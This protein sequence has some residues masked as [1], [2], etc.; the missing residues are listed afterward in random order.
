[1]ANVQAVVVK[2]TPSR[3]RF[4]VAGEPGMPQRWR[5]NNSIPLAEVVQKMEVER[6]AVI[7]YF[8]FTCEV[9]INRNGVRED[10]T[11]TNSELVF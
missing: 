10:T 2:D 9:F 11:P 8:P 6:L 1:M 7:S 4:W 3:T 5:K